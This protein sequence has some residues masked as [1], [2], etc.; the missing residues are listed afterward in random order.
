MTKIE[1]YQAKTDE[2]AKALLRDAA[3]PWVVVDTFRKL[4]PI[5]DRYATLA[6][7]QRRARDLNRN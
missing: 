4:A 2:Q 6:Q 3:R 5:V 7:A 1:R